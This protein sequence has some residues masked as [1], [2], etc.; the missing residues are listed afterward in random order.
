MLLAKSTIFSVPRSSQALLVS[1]EILSFP[2]AVP[3]LI[4]FIAD[5][6][7]NFNMPFLPIP[8]WM[9]H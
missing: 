8:L 4:E 2:V 3:F 9:F 6:I 5:L 7:Y 1:M